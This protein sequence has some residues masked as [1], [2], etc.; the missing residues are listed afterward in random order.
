MPWGRLPGE[1]ATPPLGPRVWSSLLLSGRSTVLFLSPRKARKARSLSLLLPRCHTSVPV[2][3]LPAPQRGLQGGWRAGL[4]ARRAALTAAS[5]FCSSGER[6]EVIQQE[7]ADLLKG[8][9]LVGHA[10]HNDLKVHRAAAPRGGGGGSR[11]PGFGPSEGPRFQSPG[12]SHALGGVPG[13]SWFS[14]RQ[15]RHCELGEMSAASSQQSGMPPGPG[16]RHSSTFQYTKPG[17]CRVTQLAGA[18]CSCEVRAAVCGEYPLRPPLHGHQT[19]QGSWSSS[20]QAS[21]R[22]PRGG[23][24]RPLLLEGLCCRQSRA[25][26][27]DEGAGQAEW[28]AP[29]WAWGFSNS[30]PGNPGVLRCLR[31][32]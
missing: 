30:V 8:R 31:Q 3:R 26:C 23:G 5:S 6:L 21:S 32:P 4:P 19:V 18:H 28:E 16:A 7:V 15:L 17:R 14:K 2:A 13:V 1:P 24:L 22:G 27:P 20:W 12:S 29:S 9:I 25:A 10:L 11:R